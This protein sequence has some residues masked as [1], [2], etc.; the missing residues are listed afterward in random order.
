MWGMD[1]DHSY[2]A[3]FK[4]ICFPNFIM[5][6]IVCIYVYNMY[7]SIIYVILNI[8]CICMPK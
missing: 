2:Y 1:N 5:S 4:I 8:T 3:D 6:I 7:D